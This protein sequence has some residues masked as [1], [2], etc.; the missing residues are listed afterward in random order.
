MPDAVPA[1]DDGAPSCDP[2]AASLVGDFCDALRVER[3]ASAH[4]VRAYREDME[5][6]LRWAQR[7]GVDPLAPTYR[8]RKSVV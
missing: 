4:T 1:P 2:R 3:N 5:A 6:Y 8:D 7:A